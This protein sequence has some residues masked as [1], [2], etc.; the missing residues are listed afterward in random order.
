M[1]KSVGARTQP[2]FTPL[3]IG[4]GSK[5]EPS[6]CTVPCIFSW[7][8]VMILR[9]VGEHPI[10]C[11]S[12]NRPDLLT[13]SNALVKSMK[14]MYRGRLCSRHFS[15]NCLS[16]KIMSIVDL[17]ALNPHCASGYTRS[18]SSCSLFSTTRAKVLPTMLRRDMPR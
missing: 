8:Y 10:L 14:A 6:Y 5:E 11:R 2:C 16:E 15:C 12:V 3:L 9:S 7:N 4:K 17:S 13:R 18:A 1:P